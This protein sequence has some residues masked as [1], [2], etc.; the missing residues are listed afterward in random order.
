MPDIECPHCKADASTQLI[1][2]ASKHNGCDGDVEVE[3]P[4]C[5]KKFSSYAETEYHFFTEDEEDEEQTES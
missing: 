1:E 5:K 2:A 4:S 3:C